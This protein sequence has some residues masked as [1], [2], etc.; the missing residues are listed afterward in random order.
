MEIFASLGQAFD[1]KI[2]ELEK[3]I[4]KAAAKN[5][6][7]RM[8]REVPGVGPLI[9]SAMTANVPDPGVFKSGRDFS[10]FLGLT[11]SQHSSGASRRWAPSPKGAIG[12]CA[13]PRSAAAGRRC[14]S[15]KNTRAR[16]P[17]G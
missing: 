13:R 14:A 3:N 8:L 6:M 1:E 11:P 4:A 16:W 15:P 5:P 17:T 7:S 10:A 9:A 2:D 12:I